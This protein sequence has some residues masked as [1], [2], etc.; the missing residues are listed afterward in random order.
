ME[1]L[2]KNKKD[3]KRQSENKQNEA[4]AKGI[5]RVERR[6][7]SFEKSKSYRQSII[8]YVHSRL[9]R[10][11]DFFR[12]LLGCLMATWVHGGCFLLSQRF[13][14]DLFPAEEIIIIMRKTWDRIIAYWIILVLNFEFKLETKVIDVRNSLN[15]LF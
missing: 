9:R 12:F 13:A 15:F 10:R 5:H 7:S 6:T 4:K 2:G 14:S 11:R 3:F 8:P 1:I